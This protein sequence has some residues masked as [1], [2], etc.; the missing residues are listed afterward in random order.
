M[1][2]WGAMMSKNSIR[3]AI[4]ALCCACIVSWANPCSASERTKPLLEPWNI[5]SMSGALRG[6]F[7]MP[8]QW[9]YSMGA[10]L[11]GTEPVTTDRLFSRGYQALTSEP[12]LIGFGIHTGKTSTTRLA[13]DYSF[14]KDSVQKAY[15][16]SMLLEHR[17]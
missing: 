11:L 14:L 4:V 15:V 5:W 2:F 13:F 10:N 3:G 7:N 16:V 9:M 8:G 6:A 1:D 12:G 17:W